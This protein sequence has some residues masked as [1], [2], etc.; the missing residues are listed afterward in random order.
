VH[1]I[2]DLKCPDS[3]ECENNYW[4]NLH[5]LKP[6]DQI[7]FVI[8]SRRDFDW[9]VETIKHRGLADRFT[10]LASPVFGAVTP[11]QLAE[12]TLASGLPLRLQIQLHKLIWD[13]QARGV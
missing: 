4:P 10:L 5:H 12:W 8:A 1:I 13:P 11:R 2:M 9:T 3:G 7:K 6:G